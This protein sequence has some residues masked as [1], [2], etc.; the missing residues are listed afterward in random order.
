[1][2]SISIWHWLIVLL[3]VSLVFGTRKMRTIGSDLGVAVK[4]FK[5]GVQDGTAGVATAADAPLASPARSAEFAGHTAPLAHDAT[6]PA[7]R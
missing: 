2:G 6:D 1:M 7:I 3:I 4:G 5:E